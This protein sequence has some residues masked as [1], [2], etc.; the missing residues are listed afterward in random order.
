[1]CFPDYRKSFSCVDC[2]MLYNV[3]RKKWVSVHARIFMWNLCPGQKSTVQTEQGDGL[4]PCWQSNEIRLCTLPLFIQFICGILYWK[5]LNSK[6]SCVILN[7]YYDNDSPVIVENANGLQGLVMTV[8][9]GVDNGI[10]INY[11]GDQTNDHQ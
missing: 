10:I 5:K 11:K 6:K 9:G 1:M 3:L 2:V 8:R 7:L 4:T